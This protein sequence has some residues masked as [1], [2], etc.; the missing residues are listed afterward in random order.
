M[1]PLQRGILFS[2][3]AAFEP[4]SLTILLTVTLT[5]RIISYQELIFRFIIQIRLKKPD[6]IIY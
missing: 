2:T 5:S 6:Q 1:V 4:I 3:I